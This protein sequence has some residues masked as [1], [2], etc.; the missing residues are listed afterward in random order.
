MSFE[1]SLS[2]SLASVATAGAVLSN[3]PAAQAAGIDMWLLVVCVAC[4]LYGALSTPP[5][6]GLKGIAL[7]FSGMTVSI[8]IGYISGKS[9]GNYIETNYS[10]AQGFGDK[11]IGFTVSSSFL[12]LWEP[13]LFY[14]SEFMKS[15]AGGKNA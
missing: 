9:F 4:G 2:I 11:L 3:N 1:T 10:V 12:Y 7:F 14:I 8:I 6:D 13:V 15:K 5:K